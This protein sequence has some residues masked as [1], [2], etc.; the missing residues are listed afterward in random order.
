M[1]IYCTH[2]FPEHTF[3]RKIILFLCSVP[4]FLFTHI[5]AANENN[6][7]SRTAK[8]AHSACLNETLDDYQIAKG[9][10]LNSS[11]GGEKIECIADAK[12]EKSEMKDLCREQQFARR[13][14]CDL[15]GESAYD[16]E[17][18]P[19]IFMTA[20]QMADSPNPYFPLVPG[21]QWV[22][23]KGDDE[24]IMVEVLDEFKLIEGVEC[25]TVRDTVTVD[26]EGEDVLVEDTLDWY[27]QD[28]DANVWYCGEI[29]RNYE[30]IPEDGVA[31][32]VDLEGSWKAFRD[33]A[34]PG[35]VMFANPAV[36]TV[37]RQEFDLG[38]AEDV[39]EIISISDTAT[40]MVGSCTGDCLVTRDFTPVDPGH[41]ELKVYSPGFGM[42]L[43][44]DP[45]TNEVI[46]ELIEMTTP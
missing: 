8:L 44:F 12:E 33:G 4:M 27:A 31:E 40:A 14:V 21:T 22:Y 6:I 20:T 36:G 25:R 35:I 7:C 9:K 28:V 11:D 16:P 45:E 24:T 39:A 30:F 46:A 26:I 23:A 1:K 15:I 19:E 5:G 32:L 18:E 42:I 29:S 10:C 37:Y 43:E 3:A 34:K 38:N 41:E 17:F 13:D 2:N